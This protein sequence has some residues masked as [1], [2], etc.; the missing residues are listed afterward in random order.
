MNKVSPLY[1]FFEILPGSLA[2]S[3]FII[4]I[5]IAYYF[6]RF[7]S[8][9]IIAYSVYWL[10]R[11]FLMSARM[12]H[13]YR[14]FRRDRKIDWLS[15]LKNLKISKNWRDIYHLVIVPTY[16]EDQSILVHSIESVMKSDY[17]TDRII[18][19]LATEE[20]DEENAT[21]IAKY[22]E[23]NYSDKFYKY[24]WTKHPK[25]L[26]NE[27]KGKGA[28]IYYSA[29]EV[30]KF[31]D[32][33]KIPYED[34]IVTTMDADHIVDPK[35]LP[36]LTYLYITDPDPIRK[37]FQP[38]PMYFNNIWDVP[39]PM[40]LMAMS[41]M[42]WQMVVATQPHLLRN[43]SAHA[44][45]L[46]GLIKTDFW[47]KLTSVEDGH[48]FWRSY[49]AFDG[50]HEVVPMFTPI[51]MDAIL[52]D[53]LWKT[54]KEQ[55][56]QQRR[57]SWGVSDIPFVYTKMLKDKKIGFWDK[58]YKCLLLFDSYYNWSTASFILAIV[59]WYPFIFGHQFFNSIY[60]YSFPIVYSRML[61]IA[62]V[63]LITTMVLSTLLLPPKPNRRF[64]TW[65]YYVREWILTP[66]LTPAISILFSAIPAL[67]SQ[68]R[69]MFHKYLEFRVTVKS[70]KR[71]GAV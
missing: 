41:S 17:P 34:V 35:Y 10:F 45:G 65:V 1:R 2:W 40:R 12:I 64:H 50:K 4:S 44:Q 62:W 51:Y 52:A 24:L 54:F 28:N 15:K 68:T 59:C 6:P 9:V 16:K 27:V 43:F 23:H 11:T 38:L 37:S 70:T 63:G 14:S 49:F 61:M 60:A 48:Q 19:V 5:P 21:K 69:L 71:S 56:L 42:F 53:N 22:L 67:E 46:A 57:W 32:S 55:Y 18:Y 8:S 36:N 33:K 66:I 31:I 26:P 58:L 39:S 47:S 7:F 30:L 3:T 29:K 13:G 25:D 20:R